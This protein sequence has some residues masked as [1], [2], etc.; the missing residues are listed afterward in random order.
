MNIRSLVGLA[1]PEVFDLANRVSARAKVVQSLLS[2]GR[3]LV[4]RENSGVA[5]RII[6]LCSRILGRQIL[7]LRIAFNLSC[8]AVCGFDS[9]LKAVNFPAIIRHRILDV[10]RYAGFAACGGCVEVLRR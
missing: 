10:L 6:D 4:I 8:Q 7:D 2:S 5:K 3:E 1:A 9:M